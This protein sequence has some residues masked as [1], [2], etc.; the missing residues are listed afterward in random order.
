MAKTSKAKPA[1]PSKYDIIGEHALMITRLKHIVETYRD[2]LNE[3][4]TLTRW[5]GIPEAIQANAIIFLDIAQRNAMV[6]LQ[7]IAK[8]YIQAH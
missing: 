6:D 7:N 3:A 8:A 1:P 5:D 2:A 4:D